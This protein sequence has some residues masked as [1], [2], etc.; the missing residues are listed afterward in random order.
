L[1]IKEN[2]E[3]NS[4]DERV[5]GANAMQEVCNKFVDDGGE[6]EGEQ[7]TIQIVMDIIEKIH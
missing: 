4:Y 1:R 3:S 6:E 7:A 2:L 5:T